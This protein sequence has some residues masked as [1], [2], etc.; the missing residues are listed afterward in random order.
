MGKLTIKY[1]PLS[2]IELWGRNPKLHDFGTIVESIKLHGFRNP[3]I[4]DEKQKFI[5]GG[6]GR[7]QALAMMKRDGD[8]VPDGIY[9]QNGDW[10]IP[11]VVGVDAKTKAQAEAHAV[12]DNVT[13]VLGGDATLFDITRF[14][15]DE[16]EFVTV[17]HDIYQNSEKTA[18]LSGDDVDMLMQVNVDKKPTESEKSAPE[19]LPKF[20]IQIAINNIPEID[21]ALKT[22]NDIIKSNPDWDAE[23]YKANIKGG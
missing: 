13:V 12:D 3:P 18:S 5:V 7:I 1:A 15:W 10:Y 2:K 19:G 4:Y 20:I 22:I 14:L 11:L 21:N 8:P 9:E 23:L 16:Q 17:M 6:N